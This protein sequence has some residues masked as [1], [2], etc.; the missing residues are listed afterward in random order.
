MD[1]GGNVPE[2]INQMQNLFVKLKD[3]SN[4]ELTEPW[5][6]AMLL[7]SLPRGYDTLITALEA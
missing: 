1:E 6:V 3:I 5:S 7:S 2:H 4:E